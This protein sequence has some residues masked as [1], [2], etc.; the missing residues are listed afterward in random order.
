MRLFFPTG[1]MAA[2]LTSRITR[3]V[4]PRT[5]FQCESLKCLSTSFQNRSVIPA[6]YAKIKAQQ[7]AFAVDDGKRIHEKGGA[8]NRNLY[9]FTKFVIL[10]G[11]VE[12]C[13]VWVSLVFP[14]GVKAH[15]TGIKPE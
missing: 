1:I 3:L 4:I 7:K 13:R 6:G 10:V 14:M 11:F 12:W 15:L 9:L 5:V 8:S 2:L